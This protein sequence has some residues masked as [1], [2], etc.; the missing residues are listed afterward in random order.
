MWTYKSIPFC[1]LTFFTSSFIIIHHFSHPILES[2][3]NAAWVFS[4]DSS[5]EKLDRQNSLF[6]CF[7]F[8]SSD[9]AGYPLSHFHLA[10]R[11][12]CALK[13]PF[14]PTPTITVIRVLFY[15][16]HHHHKYHIKSWQLSCN[17]WQ[18]FSISWLSLKKIPRFVRN[19]PLSLLRPFLNPQKSF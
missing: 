15:H 1:S 7:G 16:H 14:P 17:S 9:V 3:L 8:L 5:S 19:S 10:R 6:L 11:L 4:R 2:Y 12:F 13:W 18:K